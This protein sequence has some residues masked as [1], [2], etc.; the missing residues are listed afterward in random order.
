MHKSYVFALLFSANWELLTIRI[1]SFGSAIIRPHFLHSKT[2]N[3]SYIGIITLTLGSGL[4]CSTKILFT[5]T[6]F[7]CPHEGH[8]ILKVLFIFSPFQGESIGSE[9]SFSCSVE[10]FNVSCCF[11]DI[12]GYGNYFFEIKIMQKS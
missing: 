2:S 11:F 1:S 4:G 12:V 6:R 10:P 3:G 5:V 9:C 7:Q 8:F